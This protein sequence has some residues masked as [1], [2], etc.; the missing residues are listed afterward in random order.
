MFQRKKIHKVTWRHP[1][2]THENQIDHIA[3]FRK[4]RKCIADVRVM[5][6]ATVGV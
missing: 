5:K 4:F 6:G 1:N 3:Y 2:C